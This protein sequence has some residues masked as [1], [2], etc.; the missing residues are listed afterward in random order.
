[1]RASTPEI[2]E[3]IMR[4]TKDCNARHKNML[5]LLLDSTFYVMYTLRSAEA[6]QLNRL[7][8]STGMS[9]QLAATNCRK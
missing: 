2:R 4:A 5:L 7:S 9:A 1:V 6:L 8:E 3:A